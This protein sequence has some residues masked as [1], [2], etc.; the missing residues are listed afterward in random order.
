MSRLLLVP[1]DDAV[2]FPGMTL[3][4]AVDT[5]DD[6]LANLGHTVEVFAGPPAEGF[7]VSRNG[8]EAWVPERPGN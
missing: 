4:L 1:L 3:T 8:V 7:R 2:V 6:E 5:G